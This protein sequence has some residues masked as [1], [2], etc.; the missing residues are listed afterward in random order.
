VFLGKETEFDVTYLYFESSKVAEWKSVHEWLISI[1]FLTEVISDQMNVVHVVEK[2]KENPIK[3]SFLLHK[4]ETEI[5][6]KL[7]AKND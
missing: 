7:K 4:D 3:K 6:L 1:S 5:N 2:G